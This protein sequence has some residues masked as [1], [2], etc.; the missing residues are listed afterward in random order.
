MIPAGVQ[1]LTTGS[2]S[3]RRPALKG[4]RPSTSLTGDI[5]STTASAST[6]AGIGIWTRIAL[7][8]SLAFSRPTR[9]TTSSVVAF[10]DSR[11]SEVEMPTLSQLRCFIR[12]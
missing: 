10:A 7:I 2:P 6:C 4:C 1:G 8:S 3:A 9:A 5:V 12:T 11:W